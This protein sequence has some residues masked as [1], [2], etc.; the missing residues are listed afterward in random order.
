MT[1]ERSPATFLLITAE[2]ERC[3]EGESKVMVP[4]AGH[5]MHGDNPTFY[6]QAVNGLPAATLARA[7][8]VHTRDPKRAAPMNPGHGGFDRADVRLGL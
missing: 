3:L 2:L 6:N 4:E 1:G 8:T 7:R 5:G